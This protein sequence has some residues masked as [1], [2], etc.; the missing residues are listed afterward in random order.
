MKELLVPGLLRFP[1]RCLCHRLG[2]LLGWSVSLR[3][4]ISL[5]LPAT[6]RRLLQAKPTAQTPEHPA[7]RA[8]N[9]VRVTGDP[10]GRSLVGTSQGASPWAIAGSV[11]PE[12]PV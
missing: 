11:A 9:A 2:A 6:R 3:L 4:P 12:Q 1:L 7:R 8:A 5:G 10:S